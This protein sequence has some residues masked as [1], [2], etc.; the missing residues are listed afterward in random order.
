MRHDPEELV[1]HVAVALQTPLLILERRFES[2][3]RT[4]AGE[5][6]GVP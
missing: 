5:R 3:T 4:A 2:V 1:P 6:K